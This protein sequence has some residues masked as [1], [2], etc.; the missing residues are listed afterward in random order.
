LPSGRS[1]LLAEAEKAV[2][3]VE[4]I[5][6]QAEKSAA[7]A[8]GF[9]Q[10]AHDQRIQWPVIACCGGNAADVEDMFEG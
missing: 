6:G 8:G 4:V 2:V 7:A 5:D 1:A 3:L 9:D 10:D